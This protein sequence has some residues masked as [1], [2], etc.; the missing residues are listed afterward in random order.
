MPRALESSLSI[1]ASTHRRT[2]STFS[3]DIAC[4]VSHPGG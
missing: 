2:I 4:A 3:W 1:T